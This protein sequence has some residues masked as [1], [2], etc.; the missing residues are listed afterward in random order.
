MNADSDR[1]DARI[2]EIG[3]GRANDRVEF[4]QPV[5]HQPVERL[6]L[7]EADR[8]GGIVMGERAEHPADR[9]AQ[10]AIIVAD[11]LQDFR[12][13]ALI[14]GIIDGGDPEAQDVGAGLS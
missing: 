13:D 4:A 10:F 5:Q 7:R 6:H 8:A 1:D 9:V 11:G 3:V 2:V 12:A 14:V